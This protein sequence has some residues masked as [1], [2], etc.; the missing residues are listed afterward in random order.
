MNR[1][2]HILVVED[3]LS[4][5]MGLQDNLIAEGYKVTTASNG[6]DGFNLASNNNFDLLILDIMLPG[7]NGFDICKRIKKEK[8]L[9]PIV[10]LTARS[11]EMDMVS[12]LD[13]GADDY[14]TKPFSLSELLA[15]IRAVIRRAYP[16]KKELENYSFGNVTIDFKKMQAF[17]NG[18]EIKFTVKEF[19]IMEY[20]IRHS[21]EVVHRHDLLNEVWGYNV[22]PSTRT[23]DN[24]ILDIRKKVEETPSDPKHIISVSGI[25]YRFQ[26]KV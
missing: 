4:I 2:K 22:M 11:S 16:D 12:G 17:V 25:G 26:P 18:E 19:A 24:F 6:T 8:P 15:R 7:M 20:F 23:V 21:G 14:I 10:M 9:L 1:K 13:Y 5:L 3:D